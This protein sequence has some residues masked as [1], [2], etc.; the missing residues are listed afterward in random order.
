MAENLGAGFR[1]SALADKQRGRASAD[2]SDRKLP[3]EQASLH[4]LDA[5]EQ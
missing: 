1:V 2:P 5:F 3:L 4:L